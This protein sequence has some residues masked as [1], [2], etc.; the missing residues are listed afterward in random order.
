MVQVEKP[1]EQGSR[2]HSIVSDTHSDP[3]DERDFKQQQQQRPQRETVKKERAPKERVPDKDGFISPTT[4]SHPI[5]PPGS[6][7]LGEDKPETIQQLNKFAALDLE[8]D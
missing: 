3:E 7:S 8:E 6:S 1:R 4:T 2:T 5:V